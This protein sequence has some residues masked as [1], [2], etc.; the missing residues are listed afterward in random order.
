MPSSGAAPYYLKGQPPPHTAA[1]QPARAPGAPRGPQVP[2]SAPRCP[3]G[4]RGLASRLPAPSRLKPLLGF[5][6]PD[7]GNPCW[8]CKQGKRNP[9]D[10]SAHLQTHPAARPAQLTQAG[11]PPRGNTGESFPAVAGNHLTYG[12]PWGSSATLPPCR[13]TRLAQ[14][15]R[16]VGARSHTTEPA[17]GH[18]SAQRHHTAG[19]HLP[20][21]KG[22]QH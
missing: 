18:Q 16:G 21:T 13:S 4:A 9:E 19:H 5:Y 3:L 17:R 8:K 22:K 14:T 7:N 10:A 12:A 2:L 1:S 15:H 6:I 20:T 11:I